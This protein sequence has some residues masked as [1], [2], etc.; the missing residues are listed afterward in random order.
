[1]QVFPSAATVCTHSHI[2]TK[3]RLDIRQT[4]TR[5]QTQTTSAPTHIY[6]PS[7]DI[8]QT[9]KNAIK[10]RQNKHLHHADLEHNH[11]IKRTQS[12]AAFITQLPISHT[13]ITTFNGARVQGRLPPAL[14][15]ATGL[16]TKLG[17]LIGIFGAN[18]MKFSH[19]SPPGH[20][21]GRGGGRGWGDRDGGVGGWI[22]DRGVG[23]EGRGRTL[24]SRRACAPSPTVSVS[25]S[26]LALNSAIH[27]RNKHQKGKNRYEKRRKCRAP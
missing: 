18:E 1:M 16:Y 19:I 5:N 11:S 9:H 10:H 8:K 12:L 24:S 14:P 4:Q 7:L 26:F 21:R 17:A 3:P 22:E 2:Y 25:H 15:L 13:Q 23:R 27:H 6:K 20:G